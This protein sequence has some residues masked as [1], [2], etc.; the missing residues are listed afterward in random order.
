M[1]I[2]WDA[3]GSA[4]GQPVSIELWQDTATGPQLIS[5]IAASTPDT[6]LYAWS[7]SLAGITAGT[8]GLRIRI[9]S[10]ANPAVYQVSQEAFT[11]PAVGSQF[12]VA[13]NGSN[14]NTGTTA[15]APLP[16]PNNVFRDYAIGA[17]D[18]V[19]IAAGDY[20]L[21]APLTLSGATNMGLGIESG[22]TLQ[23]STNGTVN[24]HQA[25]PLITPQAI[26]LIDNASY[27]TINNLTLTGGVEGLVVDDGSNT[28]NASYLTATGQSQAGFYIDTNSP[29][30]T[31]DHLT[32]TNNGVY[33]L[34]IVGTIGAITNMTQSGDQ[35]GIYAYYVN[36]TPASIG[37]ID[38]FSFSND[39]A[40]GA[41]LYV[42]AGSTTITGSTFS[43]DATGV[44]LGGGANITFGDAN[45]AD[46]KGNIVEGTTANQ[47]L[48]A[49]GALV[50][51]NVFENNSGRADAADI[52]GGAFSYNLVLGN[53]S[54]A[55]INYSG[56]QVIG[57]RIY[58]NGNFG[59]QVNAGNVTVSQNTI[60]SNPFGIITYGAGNTFSNNLVYADTYAGLFFA[61]A[62]NNTVIN[63]TIYEPTAGSLP[64]AANPNWDVGA[65]VLDSNSTGAKLQNN[66]ITAL[67]GV[68]LFVAN[69]SQAGFSSNYNLF[70]SGANGKA[71][72]WL[73]QMQT[74]LAQ[75][76][77]ATGQDANSLSGN[78]DFVNPT[79]GASAAGYVS[80]SQTGVAD[81][82]H[83][84]SAQGSDHGG[85]L[86][87]IAGNNGLPVLPTGAYA[88]DAS[89]SPGIAAGNPATPIGAEPSPNGGIVEIGAYGGTSESSLTPSSFIAVT[90]PGA[91]ANVVQGN[92]LAIAWNAFN[93][94]GTVDISIVSGGTTT[95]L[96]SGVLD[97]GGYSWTVDGAVFAVGAAY[98]VQV[99]S[100]ANPAISGESASF[101]IVAPVHVYYVN[102][103]ATGGQYATA[104]GSD[105][106]DGL[107]AATPMA[108]LA[109]LLA[110]YTFKPGDI[111]YVDAGTYDLTNNLVFAAADFGTLALPITIQGP[112]QA[113]LT[114]T[115]NRQGTTSGFY[116]FDFK[117]ASN[118]VLNNLTITGGNVGVE[119]EDNAGST[120]I[121]IANATLSGNTYDVYDGA[122]DNNFT[123]TNS[124]IASGQSYGIE[125]SNNSN[126]TISNDKINA[127]AS[128]S[129]SYGVGVYSAANVTLSGD[130]FT[131]AGYAPV[132]LNVGSSTN[133]LGEGLSFSASDYYD[134]EFSGTSGVIETSTFNASGGSFGLQIAGSSATA[135]MVSQNNVIFGE[136]SGNSYGAALNVGNWAWSHGDTVYNSD[137]GV[138]VYGSNALA[139]GDAIYGDLLSSS[140]P[141]I[142]AAIGVLVSGGGSA[143]GNTIY[144]NTTGAAIDGTNT[145]FDNNT[146]YGNTT[147]SRSA[148]IP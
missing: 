3:F 12:Y 18:V 36:N 118:V 136:D 30:G 147:R 137:I 78:P 111:V 52:N 64:Y 31:L 37:R 146:L 51:G 73:G 10:V 26:I 123:I 48:N 97:S 103:S 124:T 105:A 114:A 72:S 13:A 59:L 71:G 133:F 33:G 143:T 49:N 127:P 121:T 102:A 19:N 58:D 140:S 87:V 27:V 7:P 1:F 92:T 84:Q 50:Y 131:G 77:A 9:A 101:S 130:V 40:Y 47:G 4:A 55:G 41:Y 138:S 141:G 17:G 74:T 116:A 128:G 100:S 108:T 95:V 23:G 107:S 113:G 119:L 15:S 94:S 79:G 110:T 32:A 75:W 44:Y 5:T 120:G 66:I 81:D 22:F 126:A 129:F 144:G 134:A 76:S 82:F 28:F 112:T 25:N 93:V 83:L 65:I 142:S 45:L 132:L 88:K 70:Q 145:I 35:F 99:A 68:A 109:K 56:A 2:T 85:S 67:S 62:A 46:G 24:L 139:S 29:S 96:A 125:I 43:G 54:G 60:Y 115:F 16:Y 6:G 21:L 117:G 104:G 39:S 8:T 57:N 89:T 80:P 38:D 34:E 61:N 148:G 122:G 86:S 53:S 135:R 98:Q 91:G 63:N 11:V 90:A 42:S 106:N 69:T 14:R 20:P